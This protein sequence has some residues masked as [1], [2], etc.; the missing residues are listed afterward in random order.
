MPPGGRVYA[1][2]HLARSAASSK[3][4][5]GDAVG[6]GFGK[7]GRPRKGSGAGEAQGT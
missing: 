1:G 4:Q 7:I 3:I 5:T 6:W 2:V